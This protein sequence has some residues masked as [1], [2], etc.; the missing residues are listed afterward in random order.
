MPKVFIVNNMEHD[1]SK[2]KHYGTL[3]DATKGRV[4]IFRTN[5]V[6]NMLEECLKD[7]TEDDYL[8]LSGPSILCVIASTILFNR[9]DTVKFLVFDAKQQDYVVRHINK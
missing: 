9:H 4:P 5:S 6:R 1:Y 2:A 3:V 7:F 8:L